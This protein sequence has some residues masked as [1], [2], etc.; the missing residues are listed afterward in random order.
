MRLQHPLQFRNLWRSH[1]ALHVDFLEHVVAANLARPLVLIEHRQRPRPLR[2]SGCEDGAEGGLLEGLQVLLLDQ[3]VEVGLSS[4]DVCAHDRHDRRLPDLGELVVVPGCVL[5]LALRVVDP[6]AARLVL[7]LDFK[8]GEV[9]LADDHVRPSHKRLRRHLVVVL[10]VQHGDADIHLGL[11]LVRDVALA[12]GQRDL[13][14]DVCGSCPV[15]L[16]LKDV[17][18]L[19]TDGAERLL[20]GRQPRFQCGHTAVPQILHLLLA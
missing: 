18:K 16:L 2:P 6:R 20:E 13:R 19:L 10:Q 9:R 4:R 17:S 5:K 14:Q 11:V 3:L 12:R 1:H 8:V 7:E 15:F